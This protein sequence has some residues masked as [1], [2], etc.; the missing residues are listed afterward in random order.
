MKALFTIQ[1]C[2]GNKCSVK[3]N[4]MVVLLSG[5]RQVC[6]NMNIMP[7]N[8]QFRS[9]IILGA[10]VSYVSRKAES[11][12]SKLLWMSAQKARSESTAKVAKDSDLKP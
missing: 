8:S 2:V 10:K 6:A 9:K 7:K 5:K 11:K 1:F 4:R 3:L 12:L